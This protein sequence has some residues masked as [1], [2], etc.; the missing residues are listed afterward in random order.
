MT[1]DLDLIDATPANGGRRRFLQAGAALAGGLLLEIG[2]AGQFIRNAGAAPITDS[3]AGNFAPNAWVRVTP[4]N[5]VLLVVHKYD[6]GTGV[7]NALGLM[8]A[9]ELDAD[10]AT[11]QVIQPDDP[12]AKAYLHPLWGMHATGGSTSVPLEWNTLR[13][14]GAT[15]RAMLVGEAARRWAVEP[16]TCKTAA[17]AVI[18]AASGRRLTYGE[19]AEGAARLPVPAEVTLKRPDEFVLI[20]KE[21]SSYRVAD[22]LTGRARYA[23]DIKLPD[24]LTAIVVH[25]PVVNARVVSFNAAEVKALPGV[26]DVFAT[27]I[28][29][30]IAHFRPDAPA[31]RPSTAP[32][33]PAWPS[34]PIISGPRSARARCSRWRGATAR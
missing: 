30:V 2:S 4:D 22:K 24:M 16:A 5:R 12:L 26:R 14:A 23:I 18:H 11:V 9:E 28:P 19:L 32:A 27:E 29:E 6:S 3:A 20:G 25:A 15:A 33:S 17:S 34:W 13:R 10:W 8:L 31:A 7:K 21:R 1:R